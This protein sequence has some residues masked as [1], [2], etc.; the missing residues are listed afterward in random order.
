M[1]CWSANHPGEIMAANP[2]TPGP[3]QEHPRVVCIDD[4][5]NVLS[6]LKL[7]LT[8]HYEVHTAGSGE[9]GLALLARLGQVPVVISDMRM[10][11]MSGAETLRE[12][13]GRSPMTTRIL[14]T[15]ATDIEAA[16]EAINTG[17]LFR[18]LLKPC[19][20]DQL[21]AALGAGVELYRLRTAER[22][23]LQ[24]TLVGSIQ[25]LVE[26]LAIADPV[27]FG[28]IG[29]LKD[30][31]LAV[32][33][34]L[35]LGE[36]WHL[37]FAALVCQIGNISLP[38]A[39]AKKLYGGQVLTMQER[40]QLEAALKLGPTVIKHI[41]RLERVRCILEE[42]ATHRP[43]GPA[44][45]TVETHILRAVL[46]YEALERTNKARSSAIQAFI[47]RRNEF[48]S[49]VTDALLDVL[50]AV[51]PG[52]D[53]GVDVA[54]HELRAGMVTATELR[55]VTGALLVPAGTEITA[56]LLARL[57]NFPKQQLPP[58]IQVQPS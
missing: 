38:E 42:L 51:Q 37:E 17:D 36:P 9:E 52:N 39:T 1:R 45:S 3:S 4:E 12:V 15:G 49:A 27:A 29:R 25:A 48:N 33:A 13:A 20:A 34:K 44:T 41:P 58:R 40:I 31:A 57:M 14:L 54:L 6:S 53:A 47:L 10:P 22:D 19:S 28:R 16:A 35:G 50:G 32:A 26:V 7:L 23:L 8:R 30:L 43:G 21:R 24:R 55:A 11:G 46:A 2:I 5:P 56:G 18:F